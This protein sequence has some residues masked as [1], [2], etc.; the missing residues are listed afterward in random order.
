L[1]ALRGV[2]KIL[3]IGKDCAISVLK[4]PQE[5][6]PPLGRMA[7]PDEE[8]RARQATAQENGGGPAGATEEPRGDPDTSTA[9]T[10]GWELA[11][12]LR[13]A[14]YEAEDGKEE[15]ARLLRLDALSPLMRA[16]LATD[17]VESNLGRLHPRLAPNKIVSIHLVD[18][19]RSAL[20]KQPAALEAAIKTIHLRMLFAFAA[21]DAGLGR[22]YALGYELADVCLEPSDQC[23]FEDAFGIQVIPIKDRLADLASSFPP[24]ASRAVVLSLRAWESWSAEPELNGNRLVWASDGAGVKETLRRQGVL[25]RDLLAG[26]KRGQDMLDTGHYVQAASS[27]V[28]T[29]VPTLWRFAKPIWQPLAA[30]SGVL[31][32]GALLFAFVPGAGK[33]LGTIL[34]L[35]GAIGITSASLKARLGEVTGELQSQL[36]GAEL[37]RA[38]A[39]AV[40][41]G[42]VGWDAKVE[43][44]HVPA[45][46]AEPRVAANLKTL[47][48]FRRLIE[49]RPKR[50][51]RD[52]F[53]NKVRNEVRDLLSPDA[54]FISADGEV[55]KGAK[56]IARRLREPQVQ[57]IGS[58]PGRVDAVAPGILV[59][60]RDDGAAVWRVREG[61][62]RWRRAFTDPKAALAMALSLGPRRLGRNGQSDANS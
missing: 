39:E 28:A 6:E 59:S 51:I 16:E 52:P 20:R 7:S 9:F 43:D 40:L 26:D 18:G 17:L 4:A 32:L 31:L 34:A 58:A 46:G 45:S 22:A 55:L 61:K 37:D 33:A 14:P 48:T 5:T 24:H 60:S 29:M 12:I 23:S 11:S 3:W 19:I 30:M 57:R 10:I 44:I 53:A 56:E 27:M 41:V 8:H 36:W 62:V 1:G 35:A 13:N 2:A 50:T 47:A 15:A 49:T 54:E 21:A 25:W 42:P 38:I